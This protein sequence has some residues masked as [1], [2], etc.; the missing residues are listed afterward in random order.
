MTRIAELYAVEA[1]IREQT[2]D[3]R[4]ARQAR[5]IPL[6]DALFAFVAGRPPHISHRSDLAKIIRYGMKRR[7]GLTRFD[8][9]G[10]IKMDSN[11]AERLI[12]RSR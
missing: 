4:A 1:K 8:D 9:D 3:A 7:E 6:V 11:I 2:A 5:S 10:R 12:A